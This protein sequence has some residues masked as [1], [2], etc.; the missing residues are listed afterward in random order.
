MQ[1]CVVSHGITHVENT[2]ARN[3]GTFWTNSGHQDLHRSSIIAHTI[4]M[5]GAPDQD[6]FPFPVHSLRSSLS[7]IVHIAFCYAQFSSYNKLLTKKSGSTRFGNHPIYFSPY[8]KKLHTVHI[9]TLF[10]K[11]A[12]INVLFHFQI[13]RI[14]RRT[15]G[16]IAWQIYLTPVKSGYCATEISTNIYCQSGIDARV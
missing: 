5:L 7:R 3:C 13:D 1:F 8:Y 16:A 4:R 2:I 6:Q 14:F 12:N 11:Q 15:T 10:M 9:I